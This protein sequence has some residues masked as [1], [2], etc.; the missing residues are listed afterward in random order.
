LQLRWG[1][2]DLLAK[3]FGP[4]LKF[5]NGFAWDNE[6]A[7][8][9]YYLRLVLATVDFEHPELK[10]VGALRSCAKVQ[11]LWHDYVEKQAVPQ[12]ESPETWFRRIAEA[13]R[14]IDEMP[15]NT[16][17]SM[18]CEVQML[19]AQYHHARSKMHEIYK[20]LRTANE[21]CLPSLLWYCFV[22]GR[23]LFNG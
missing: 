17:I 18:P 6:E 5:K 19:P 16:R 4:F 20:V 8:Q 23:L 3:R 9:R 7:K 11:Q 13:R 22:N 2:Y 21:V 14:W 1:R 15:S 10:T 12:S